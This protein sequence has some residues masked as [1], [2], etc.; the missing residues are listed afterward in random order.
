V[1]VCV[2]ENTIAPHLQPSI[3]MKSSFHTHAHTLKHTSKLSQTHLE[4]VCH[5]VDGRLNLTPTVTLVR[6]VQAVAVIVVV[7]VWLHK[8]AAA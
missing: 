4:V 6:P 5:N 7:I 3:E 2:F 8:A 1:C